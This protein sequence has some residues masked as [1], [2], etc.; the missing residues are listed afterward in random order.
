MG[1]YEITTSVLSYKDL[2]GNQRLFFFFFFGIK[3]ERFKLCCSLCCVMFRQEEKRSVTL[4]SLFK[5]ESALFTGNIHVEK[6]IQL[7]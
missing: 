2:E 6:S 5:Y 1:D 4:D 7:Q 3:S